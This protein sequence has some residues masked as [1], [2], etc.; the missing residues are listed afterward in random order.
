MLE[1]HVQG[2]SLGA[3]VELIDIDA[4]ALGG[5]ILRIV[6]APLRLFLGGGVVSQPV[7]WRGNIYTPHPLETDGWEWNN[8]G[9]PPSPKIRVANVDLSFTGLNIE[10]GD[11]VGATLTRWRTFD[12]F[13]D[14]QPEADPDSH[15][16]LDI[17]KIDRKSLQTKSIVEYELASPVDQTGVLLPSD[18]V[19]KKYCQWS[20]RHWTGLEFNYEKVIG[21]PYV[22]NNYFDKDGNTTADPAQDICGKRTTDCKKRFPTGPLPFGGYP[23]VA[24]VRQ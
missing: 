21:C 12:K 9:T 13:L 22:G 3:L 5:T 18:A 1:A 8:S 6:P 24:Q 16:Q 20:Y 23:G 10:Y 14:G 2:S 17:F 7:T 11:L 4:T 15:F 19:I